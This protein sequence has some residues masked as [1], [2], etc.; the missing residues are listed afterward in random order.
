LQENPYQI[1]ELDTLDYP[2]LHEAYQYWCTKKGTK[3]RIAPAWSDISLLDLPTV[4]VPKIC[5]VDVQPDPLDFTYRYWGTA[6]TSLQHYDLSGKSVTRNTPPAYAQCIWDQY[7]LVVQKRQPHTFITEV[8]L[9]GGYST[10]YIAL[11]MPLSADGETIDKIFTAEEFG[12]DRG[13]LK[14]IFDSAKLS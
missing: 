12:E 9:E 2:D 5:I 10:Y 14:K 4:L 13:Q 1:L 8:P 7:N 11:R 3:D 6:V